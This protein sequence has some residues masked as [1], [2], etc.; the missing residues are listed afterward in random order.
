MKARLVRSDQTRLDQLNVAEKS[1]SENLFHEERATFQHDSST[2]RSD[3]IET[4]M[5]IMERKVV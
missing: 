2:R 5:A 4:K 1:G 3:D